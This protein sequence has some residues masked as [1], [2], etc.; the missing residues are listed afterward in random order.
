MQ[1]VDFKIQLVFKNRY[2]AVVGQSWVE[3]IITPSAY[4]RHT[5]RRPLSLVISAPGRSA[6]VWGDG[7]QCHGGAGMWAAR[8]RSSTSSRRRCASSTAWRHE[9]PPGAP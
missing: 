4:C 3:R 9:P 1:W 2:T 5:Q 7:A 8:S 6:G